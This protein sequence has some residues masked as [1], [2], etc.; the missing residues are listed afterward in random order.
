MNEEFPTDAERVAPE[1]VATRVPFRQSWPLFAAVCR[2]I[3]GTDLAPGIAEYLRIGPQ[4]VRDWRAG[5]AGI[6]AW[7]IAKLRAETSAAAAALDRIEPGPGRTGDIQKR[8][9]PKR[10]KPR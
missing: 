10:K 6:P 1:G 8:Y 3:I 4:M 9:G 5:K 7:V 2:R